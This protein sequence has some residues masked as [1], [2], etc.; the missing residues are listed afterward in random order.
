MILISIVINLIEE[1][2]YNDD[3]LTK[4]KIFRT[5]KLLLAIEKKDHQIYDKLFV[6]E[7]LQRSLE[8]LRLFQFDNT[9]IYSKLIN[10][11]E[12]EIEFEHIEDDFFPHVF[13][14]P[15]QIFPENFLL[16][17]NLWVNPIALAYK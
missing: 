11:E 12:L 17:E 15:N 6:S 16:H 9:S 10:S 3:L 8:V 13:H 2:L 4:G 1:N 7:K 14:I 5:A